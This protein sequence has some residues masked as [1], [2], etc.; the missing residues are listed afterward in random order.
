TLSQARILDLE[1]LGRFWPLLLIGVGL[2]KVRQPL[3]EG[4]RAAGVAL[5]FAGGL[6]QLVSILTWGRAWP[7]VLVVAGAF[8]L[9]QAMD[10]A[11]APLPPPPPSPYISE[12]ALVGAAKRALRHDDLRGGYITAVMGGVELD[13]RKSRLGASP[14]VLDVVALW[15]GIDLKVPS[16]WRVDVKV[17]PL[18]GGL[19]DKTQPPV[20]SV[21][22]PRLVVRG[23]AVMGAVLI[24]N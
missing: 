4:Q 9:W 13:L 23:Y 8:L 21:D 16:E 3:E 10:R 6:F 22:G 11:P 15:G 14:V 18:M 2:V 12:L 17:V 1:G 20:G 24:G 5:L 7:L 19:E